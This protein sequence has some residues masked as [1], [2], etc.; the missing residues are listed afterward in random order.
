[1]KVVAKERTRQGTGASR[2][3]RNAGW[4]PGVVYGAGKAPQLISVDHNTLWHALHDEAFHSSILEMELDGTSDKVL[5][6]DV[7]VH[8]FRRLV[9]HVDFQRI[10]ATEKITVNIPLNYIGEENSDAVKLYNCFIDY[11][12][13]EIEISCLPADLPENIVVDLSSAQVGDTFMLADV[14]LPEGVELVL[15]G[16]DIE[17]FVLATVVEPSN[18][19]PEELDEDA[20]GL[21]D[22]AAE[23]EGEGEEGADDDASEDS[24]DA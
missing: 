14:K 7:Q 12:L 21:L 23:G 4:T 15:R 10:S 16:R 2:R 1:M 9:L 22:G 20:E 8:P 17:D 11:I 6:R 3:L 24:K 18:E 13:T 5:L 19:E